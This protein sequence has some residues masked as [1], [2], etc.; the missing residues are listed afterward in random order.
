MEAEKVAAWIGSRFRFNPWN[1]VYSK[2]IT[3][4]PQGH[5]ILWFVFPGYLIGLDPTFMQIKDPALFEKWVAITKG[6][7][8]MPAQQIYEDFAAEYILTDLR[9][10]KFI[11]RVGDDP[12][13]VEV[14]RDEEAIIYKVNH[15]PG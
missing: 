15:P 8:D 3:G 13:V 5:E 14:F 10:K 2:R 7:V 4:K 6:E 11:D 1:M 9:H 12:A